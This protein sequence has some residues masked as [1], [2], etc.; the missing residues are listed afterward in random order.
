MPQAADELPPTSARCTLSSF[1]RSPTPLLLLLLVLQIRT[2]PPS[3]PQLARAAAPIS[4]NHLR[5]TLAAQRLAPD[6]VLALDGGRQVA[7]RRDG[8]ENG[9]GDQAR[10]HGDDGQPLHRTHDGVRAGAHVVCRDAA[11]G[12]VKARRGRADAEEQRDFDEE[13]DKRGG[14]VARS[15]VVWRARAGALDL[16]GEGGED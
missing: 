6:K 13:D 14:S 4:N 10:G 9:R 5:H 15:A 2:R 11:D 16:H 7:Q 1:I 12:G 8:Q 3:I